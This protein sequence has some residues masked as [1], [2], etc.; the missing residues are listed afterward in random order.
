MDS[1]FPSFL[2]PVVLKEM[3]YLKPGD[4]F[5]VFRKSNTYTL[6]NI[7]SIYWIVAIGCL[8]YL[9]HE[10]LRHCIRTAG[11]LALLFALIAKIS[12][13]A[14]DSRVNLYNE[15]VRESNKQQVTVYS[16]L[17]KQRKVVEKELKKAQEIIEKSQT[18]IDTLEYEAGCL[19]SYKD[20]FHTSQEVIALL[21]KREAVR[22][23]K[24]PLVE[25]CNKQYK[26]YKSKIRVYEHK[27]ALQSKI[28]SH[29]TA[30]TQNFKKEQS[31]DLETE[32]SQK[33]PRHSNSTGAPSTP[34]QKG[35]RR[36]SQGTPD[37]LPQS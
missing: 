5:I 16:D 6:S 24:E 3:P 28:S 32:R 23:E 7:R 21:E 20:A 19:R 18:K 30:H 2:S 26:V 1:S 31:V 34:T 10:D 36:S 33:P 14:E 13:A 29:A 8:A 17:I 15:R 25:Q 35:S 27:L 11:Y 12:K 37:G 4:F 9:T 22:K